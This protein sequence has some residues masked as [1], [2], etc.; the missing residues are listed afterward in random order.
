MASRSALINVMIR[1]ADKAARSLKRDFGEV[2]NLQV[3][4]KGPADFVSAA[5]LRAEEVLSRELARARPDYGLLM[6]ES[7]HRHGPKAGERRWIVDPLDGTSNFLHGLPHFAISI[8]LEER[9]ELIAGVIYDPIKDDM[10]FAEKGAG[11]YLNDRRIRVS[12]RRR[13]ED[14]LIAT[15]A[16][17][18]GHGNTSRF[19]AETAAV[20]DTTAG[21][22]RWGAAALD[23]A[24]V[25]AGRYEGF[26]ERGLSS[27]DMAA[28]IVIVREAGGYVTEIEG[29]PIRHDSPSILAAND[30]LHGALERLLRGADSGLE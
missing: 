22:R 7:G 14:S 2:A 27:W 15:G 30:S 10:F 3:S 26:W 24:Y 21:V 9:G 28:G 13:L 16:P 5:D 25:A 8:G 4:R 20:I 6:E 18:K 23:L 12:S 1:A 29:A 17:W 11:A 19:L